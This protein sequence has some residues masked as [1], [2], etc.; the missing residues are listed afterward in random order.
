MS[1]K[2]GVLGDEVR[3]ESALMGERAA[4]EGELLSAVGRG[5][6]EQAFGSFVSEARF[7]TWDARA[8]EVLALAGWRSYQPVSSLLRQFELKK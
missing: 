5:R 8:G 2:V 6:A 4:R 7:T 3:K 1:K